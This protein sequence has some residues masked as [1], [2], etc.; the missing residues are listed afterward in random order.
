MGRLGRLFSTHA[1]VR[2]KTSPVLMGAYMKKRH[3][4][5]RVGNIR[6]KRP[7][8]ARVVIGR[9]RADIG[10]ESIDQILAKIFRPVAG[11]NH[12]PPQ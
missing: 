1:G 5:K 11:M 12:N 3:E 7:K 9:P 10:G 2:E 6:P 8:K 4:A